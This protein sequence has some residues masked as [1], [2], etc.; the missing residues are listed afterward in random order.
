M[1]T[2]GVLYILYNGF[3]RNLGKSQPLGL[4]DRHGAAIHPELVEAAVEAMPAQREI[5]AAS[6][7]LKVVGD[8]T[9]MR[10][11]TALSGLELPVGDLQAVLKMSQSA[12]SHQLRVLRSAHLVKSRRAGKMVY[13]S[14][15][16]DHVQDLLRV[17]L[18]HIRHSQNP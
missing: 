3:V 5:Q 7:L 14:L 4:S 8:P 16:D 11:L 18:E 9:R 1:T 13:Y 6:E 17:S 15:A 12:V 2:T 10:I